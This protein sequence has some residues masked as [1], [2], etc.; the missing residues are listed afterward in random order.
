MWCNDVVYSKTIDGLQSFVF[1]FASSKRDFARIF[2]SIQQ[3]STLTLPKSV[4]R[5]R[6]NFDPHRTGIY[7]E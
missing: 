5:R 3:E 1:S 6:G 2:G 4:H 7:S